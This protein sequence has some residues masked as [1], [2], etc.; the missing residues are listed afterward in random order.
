M[1]GSIHLSSSRIG[2]H[3]RVRK[4]VYLEGKE[5]VCSGVNVRLA[6][7]RGPPFMWKGD[8]RRIDK[9]QR[10]AGT[11]EGSR[12]GIRLVVRRILNSIRHR[13]VVYVV[14]RRVTMAG[15]RTA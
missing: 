9:V 15:I 6:P 5:L 14:V 7:S 1:E 3:V 13:E 2:I 11:G 4:W 10:G 12:G 8:R